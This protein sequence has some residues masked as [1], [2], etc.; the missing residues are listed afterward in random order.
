MFKKLSNN[1]SNIFGVKKKRSKANLRLIYIIVGVLVVYYTYSTFYANRN[2]PH[3]AFYS[4]GFENKK[5]LVFFHMN[6]CGH[7]TKMMP[8][9]HAFEKN[10]KTNIATKKIERSQAPELIDRHNIQGFP[11]IMLLDSKN[12]KIKDY[13]GERTS[14]GFHEFCKKI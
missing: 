4:E 1:I 14:S 12:D 5:T 8:E 6:G 3:N 13:D 7:C 9:W 10:N 11:S 2:K